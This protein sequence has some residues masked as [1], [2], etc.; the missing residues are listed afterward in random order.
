MIRDISSSPSFFKI[1]DCIDFRLDH[2]MADIYL[3]NAV[4]KHVIK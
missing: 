3:N 1:R 4:L 2:I